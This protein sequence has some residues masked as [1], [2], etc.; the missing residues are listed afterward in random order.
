MTY[1]IIDGDATRLVLILRIARIVEAQEDRG[2][3]FS[4]TNGSKTSA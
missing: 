4:K 2:L 1:T 3:L